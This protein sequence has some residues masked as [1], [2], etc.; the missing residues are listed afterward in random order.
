[1][2]VPPPVTAGVLWEFLGKGASAQ[3]EAAGGGVVPPPPG[4]LA[5]WPRRGLCYKARKVAQPLVHPRG[6]RTR[7]RRRTQW[8][9]PAAPPA[10]TEAPARSPLG[11]GVRAGGSSGQVMTL[12]G[13]PLFGEWPGRGAAS[14]GRK[15][16][17]ARLCSLARLLFLSLFC[18]P[19]IYPPTVC[20]RPLCGAGLWGGAPNSDKF[21]CMGKISNRLPRTKP[22]PSECPPRLSPKNDQVP[23]PAHPT[24]L[25]YT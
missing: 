5:W 21:I 9:R 23:T 10:S 24:D 22:N 14:R 12:E 18:S 17:R 7:S 8:P 15:G 25:P 16:S 6:G 13:R 11:E 4:S 1:M 19:L 20:Q 3:A 2:R